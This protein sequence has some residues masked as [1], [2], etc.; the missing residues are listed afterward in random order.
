M[1][2]LMEDV[3]NRRDA[4][5]AETA[6]DLWQRAEGIPVNQGAYVADLYRVEVTPWPRTGQQGAF[7][8]LAG[9]Q[10]DDAYVLE[11]APAGQTEAMHHLFEAAIYV[12]DGRG[13]TTIWQPG[14]AKQTVE[15]QKGSVFSPPL[16][17]YYQHFNLEGQQPARLFAVT[18]APM[19]INILRDPE[20]VFQVDHAFEGRFAGE[21]NYFTRP[22]VRLGRNAWATNFIP[23]IRAF[24]LDSAANRGAS[25]F[26]TT[27]SLS[28]NSMA[29][30]CSE[31]PPGTY[32]KAHR[33]GVGAHVVI[34][35]GHGYSLLWHEGQEPEKVEWQD[36]SV[37]S[38]REQEYHQHFNTGPTSA[39][40]L[41]LRLGLLDSRRWGGGEVPTHQIE[42]EEE[43]PAIYERYAQECSKS[44]AEVVL[45][46][47]LYSHR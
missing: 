37:L 7:V 20:F 40:Y 34:L 12:L 33:H 35:G 38:P 45:P 27:F 22:D 47:P 43:D 41:A 32:K 23:D 1:G 44:G 14:Q 24:G 28:N 9:Q 21:A 4:S 31:F 25:G 19:M 30:H 26:L 42:Y 29:A 2:A 5:R 16:N 18:N 10:H 15:W 3:P 17:A 13:A 11:I 6:Y 36:G 39:R 8:N 46:R